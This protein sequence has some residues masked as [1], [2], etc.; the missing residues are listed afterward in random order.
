MY[1]SHPIKFQIIL[2]INC[3]KCVCIK[4]STCQQFGYRLLVS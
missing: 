2:T 1:I 4:V 3:R